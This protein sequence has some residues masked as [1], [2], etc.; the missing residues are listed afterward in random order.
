M[1]APFPIAKLFSLQ[2]I[3]EWRVGSHWEN[4]C[5]TKVTHSSSLHN[6]MGDQ[7][8]FGCFLAACIL[9]GVAL[10]PKGATIFSGPLFPV[11]MTR[12][13]APHS[14]THQG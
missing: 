13:A 4:L 8:A 5:C 7:A 14:L 3:F 12:Q 6:N 1:L 11:P 2:L 9:I 10:T